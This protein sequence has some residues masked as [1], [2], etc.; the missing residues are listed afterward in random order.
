[1]KL[2]VHVT[3]SAPFLLEVD[4]TATIEQLHDL[5]TNAYLELY[6]RNPHILKL[7]RA[8]KFAFDTCLLIYEK[9]DIQPDVPIDISLQESL[10]IYEEPQPSPK[11]PILIPCPGGHVSQ[12]VPKH[13]SL[14]RLLL[15]ITDKDAPLYLQEVFFHFF[16]IW[17]SP[18]VVLKKLLDRFNVPPP[19]NA[20]PAQKKFWIVSIKHPV[21]R[22]TA[23]AIYKFIEIRRELISNQMMDDVIDWLSQL[24]SNGHQLAANQIRDLIDN[25]PD[26]T[27]VDL[28]TSLCPPETQKTKSFWEF[29]LDHLSKV[30]THVDLQSYLAMKPND[31]IGQKYVKKKELVPGIVRNIQLFNQLS[32]YVTYSI[33]KVKDNK[34]RK[35]L[36]LKSIAL[37]EKLFDDNSFNAA[38][39]VVIGVTN[40]AV[41][42][43]NA[44]QAQ[45]TPQTKAKVQELTQFINPKGNYKLYRSALRSLSRNDI[46]AP[47]FGVFL[48]DLTFIEDGNPKVVNSQ[49]NFY[50]AMLSYNTIT[51]CLTWQGSARKLDFSSIDYS[52]MVDVENHEVIDD[53]MLY[54]L[55]LDM[56]P[57]ANRN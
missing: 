6:E 55:S 18:S 17:T 36:Y 49:L 30:L 9:I 13:A 12:L 26:N 22:S 37:A 3:D 4:E 24:K 15:T 44:I 34:E 51:Q 8:C 32:N 19:T 23:R 54:Q 31:F 35:N 25:P 27:S 1:M 57:R 11:T 45:I 53:K 48:R 2:Y 20:T 43:L 29:E 14:N 39:A 7:Q 52:C 50:R 28:T 41:K 38:S 47:W 33:L 10:P 40:A 46:V 16:D 5:A 42:R 56:Q 21:E